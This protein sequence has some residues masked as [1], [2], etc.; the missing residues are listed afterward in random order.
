MDTNTFAA[1]ELRCFAPLCPLC[2]A[3]ED[4]AHDRVWC[5]SASSEE[6]A[7]HATPALIRE[8][9]Q[10]GPGSAFFC[11]AIGCHPAKNRPRLVILVRNGIYVNYLTMEEDIYQYLDLGGVQGEESFI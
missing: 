9:V 5:C 3:G 7:K 4:I 2:N 10:V 6:R 11:K 1:N 8:A